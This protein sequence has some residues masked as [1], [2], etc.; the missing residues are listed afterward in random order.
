[1]SG[2]SAE[3]DARVSIINAVKTPLGFFTLVILVIESIFLAES[4]ITA[5]TPAWMPFSLMALVV[6][7][8]SLIAWFRP[9][10]LNPSQPDRYVAM[11]FPEGEQIDFNDDSGVLVVR[12][13]VGTSTST[14]F[15]PSCD[16]EGGWYHRLPNNVHS[17]DQIRITVTDTQN[18]T[19]RTT[20]FVPRSIPRE[21]N[22]VVA[23]G[24]G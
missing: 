11:I 10:A 17:D 21:M 12:P 3:A 7:C 15:T 1:M 18:R 5:Q 22:P 16:E 4:A 6:V 9:R 2:S 8:V 23:G 19:W 20:P 14:K 13:R 24:G